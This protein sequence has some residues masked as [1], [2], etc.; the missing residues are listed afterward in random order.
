MKK[1]IIAVM[2]ILSAVA[3][4]GTIKTWVNGDTL[5]APDLNAVFQ[6]IH[7]NMV[8]GHGARLMNSDVN[9]SAAIAHSKLATPA[10]IP[11][12]WGLN[13]T[14]CG[15]PVCNNPLTVS[16]GI[17]SV[18]HTA[19]GTWIITWSTARVDALYVVFATARE[20]NTSCITRDLTTTTATV[21]C[22]TASTGVATN[23]FWQVLMLDNL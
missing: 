9:A 1:S 22:Y 23:A 10:L 13:D 2:L 18:S 20:I 21:V 16:S 15:V 14:N 12:A 19:T 6:H 5:I 11:K 17:A 8:G 4:G 3:V 7:N